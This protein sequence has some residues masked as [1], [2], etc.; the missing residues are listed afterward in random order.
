ML[1]TEKVRPNK[2]NE[3]VP[4]ADPKKQAFID[5]IKQYKEEY[6]KDNA[7]QT[8]ADDALRELSEIPYTANNFT[9]PNISEKAS[10]I[11]DKLANLMKENTITKPSRQG[12][13]SSDHHAPDEEKNILRDCRFLQL[14]G[15]V[16]H[17]I[18]TQGEELITP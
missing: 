11:I 6:N 16:G 3:A 13:L 1:Y 7:F 5:K 15:N 14:G 8:V 18:S 12:S 2:S 10:N 9:M 4:K 17:L